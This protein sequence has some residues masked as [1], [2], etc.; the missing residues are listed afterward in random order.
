MSQTPTQLPAITEPHAD[1]ANFDRI[2][3]LY[4]PLEYL[5]LGRAL[6]RCRLH[7][8]SRLQCRTRALVLGDGDGRFLA[9]LLHENPTLH[10][11]AIDTSGAMLELLRRRCRAAQT[12]LRTRQIDALTFAANQPA[13]AYD[14]VVTHF[15]LDCL[16][17]PELDLL[18]ARIVPHLAPGAL[19]LVS[20]FR[21]PTG[22]WAL[23]ARIFVRGLYLA[24]R[25]LTGL[26]VVSLPDHE[27]ALT[28]AG[29]TRIALHHSLSG[30]L[31][32]ELWST[33]QT[34]DPVP[35]PTTSAQ[36]TDS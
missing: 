13:T 27:T 10:A 11:E 22:R 2:A 26:R 35:L 31:T 36:P 32:T 14:V 4:R 5:T 18:A 8:L 23:P 25:M 21:I 20:D 29:L 24:F 1:A 7:H 19:W 6:E 9:Q 34:R 16:T 15:F 12:R 17:Q 28:R 33:R 3:K 30:I